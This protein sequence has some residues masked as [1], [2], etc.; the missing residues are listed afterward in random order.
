LLEISCNR[1][2]AYFDCKSTVYD[3]LQKT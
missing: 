3:K 1:H 2:F